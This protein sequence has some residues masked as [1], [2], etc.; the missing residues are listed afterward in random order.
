MAAASSPAVVSASSAD[1]EEGPVQYA[2]CKGSLMTNTEGKRGW[3]VVCVRESEADAK[4]IATQLENANRY[5]VF[6]EH[7]SREKGTS[8]PG[9]GSKAL[10]ARNT[11]DNYKKFVREAK[12]NDPSMARLFSVQRVTPAAAPPDAAAATTAATADK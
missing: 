2:V 12:L 9:N 11:P 8:A 6:L 1:E 3:R 7:L 10:A 4:E 5:A